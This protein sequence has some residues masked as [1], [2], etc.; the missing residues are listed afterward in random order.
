MKH[1]IIYSPLKNPLL[2]T[3]S[4][5]EIP[6][7]TEEIPSFKISETT[8]VSFTLDRGFTLPGHKLTSLLFCKLKDEDARIFFTA[9]GKIFL[10]MPTFDVNVEQTFQEGF[11]EYVI[12]FD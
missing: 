3:N 5:S 10:D 8:Y 11:S 7:Y 9:M 4:K 1:F 12:F 6:T 2:L